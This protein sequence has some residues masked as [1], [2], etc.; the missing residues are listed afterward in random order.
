MMIRVKMKV[1]LLRIL[2]QSQRWYVVPLHVCI[3]FLKT[4]KQGWGNIF[5][6]CY[7]SLAMYAFL[8]MLL[9]DGSQKAT[10]IGARG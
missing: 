4:N 5:G 1:K 3:T 10:T 9:V 6:G 8:Y 2:R 7:C